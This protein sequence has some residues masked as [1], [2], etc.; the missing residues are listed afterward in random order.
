MPAN[1]TINVAEDNVSD[2]DSTKKYKDDLDYLKHSHTLS[3]NVK[4]PPIGLGCWMGNATEEEVRKTIK[5]AI[6][7]GYRYFDTATLYGN[8]RIVGEVVREAIDQKLVTRSELFISTKLSFISHRPD[9][10]EKAILKSLEVLGLDYL[11]MY[12]MHTPLPFKPN[13]EMT[14]ALRDEDKNFIVEDIPLI[15]T[16][17][18]LEKY[19]KKGV[20][21]SLGI[22]NFNIEQ[23]K[24]V[25]DQCEVPPHN[26]Q[27][28]IHIYLSQSQ[29][30]DYCKANNITVTGYSTLGSPGRKENPVG[31]FVD[32][33]CLENEIVKRLAVK[34]GRT[35]GQILLR[36]AIQRGLIVI[37]KSSNPVRLKQNL[38]I[39]DFKI[40]P[41]EIVELDG[42]DQDK[43]F[44]PFDFA[45]HHP[46]YPFT[47]PIDSSTATTTGLAS[48]G[49]HQA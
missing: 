25:L 47:R 9:N 3:N 31:S 10:A 6:E 49:R 35:T 38:N 40:S 23:T 15:N 22:S 20:I 39:F 7:A 46:N 33:S 42:E 5:N 21:K 16:W 1:G 14:E 11:D 24:Q 27:T 30:V 17:R 19:Y 48:E 44:F 45:Y 26:L 18:V 41:E 4:I 36:H 37:P 12:L 8:E 32:G 13:E 34:Y 28:E 2:G 29:L 43:H